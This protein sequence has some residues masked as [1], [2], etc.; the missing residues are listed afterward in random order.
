MQNIR[1]GIDIEAFFDF[2]RV[3]KIIEPYP[4]QFASRNGFGRCFLIG[5]YFYKCLMFNRF[6]RNCGLLITF[7]Q[8]F[9][10]KCG[11]KWIILYFYRVYVAISGKY[12]S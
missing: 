2:L 8:L 6:K 10:G 9:V 5:M 3:A 11:G 1:R 12:R 4:Y 7:S